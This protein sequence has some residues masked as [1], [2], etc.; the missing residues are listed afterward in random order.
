MVKVNSLGD[1][2]APATDIETKLININTA[3]TSELDLLPGIGI[4][5]AEDIVSYRTKTPFIKLEDLMNVS[6]IGETTF[7]KIKNLITI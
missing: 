1:V 5:R 6:G 3:G 4:T 7:A 2:K